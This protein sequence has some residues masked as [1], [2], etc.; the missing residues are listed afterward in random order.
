MKTMGPM[1]RGAVY[2]L[3]AIVPLAGCGDDTAADGT[4]VVAP[5]ALTVSYPS[6][7][8]GTDR[9]AGPLEFQV[10]DATGNP[11][12]GVKVRFFAGGEVFALTNR[13]NV[14]LNSDARFFETTTDDRGMSPTDIYAWW[15]VP[16]CDLTADVAVNGTVQATVGVASANWT[17][18][19][20]VKKPT[21]TAPTSC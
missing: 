20:T 3:F 18:S 13:A 11:V 9:T 14:A 8:G 16:S 15:N 2:L 5:G 4:T 7:N 6:G 12:P 17:V 10:S 19:I 1:L 21:G